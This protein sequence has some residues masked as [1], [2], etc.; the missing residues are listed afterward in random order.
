MG[1]SQ[2]PG[3][4]HF[5]QCQV[6]GDGRAA[7]EYLSGSGKHS[8]REHPVPALAL[9][10]MNPAQVPGFEVLEW[11]RNNADYA[12]TNGSPLNRVLWELLP[13]CPARLLAVMDTKSGD[14]G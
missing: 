1:T 13:T 11:I 6:V 4:A 12:R 10:D 9:L 7:I 2:K 5:G 14:A 8:D 3:S